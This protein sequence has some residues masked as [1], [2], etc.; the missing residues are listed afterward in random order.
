MAMADIRS[1][2]ETLVANVLKTVVF[3]T[4]FSTIVGTNYE[5]K[6]DIFNDADEW[7]MSVIPTNLTRYGFDVTSP[8]S[9]YVGYTATAHQ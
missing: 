3:T 9:G 5:L 8:E 7:I 4:P 6:A 1:G 2:R